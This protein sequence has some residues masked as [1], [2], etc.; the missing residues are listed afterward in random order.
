M[1]IEVSIHRNGINDAGSLIIVVVVAAAAQG[2]CALGGI[3]GAHIGGVAA[4]A[5]AGAGGKPEEL[6]TLGI[7]NVVNL[8]ESSAY[9]CPSGSSHIKFERG[10]RS[11]YHS[12]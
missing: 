1:E 7:S 2:K 8:A 6:K 11:D 5:I 10:S 4:Q 3:N 12:G 9:G